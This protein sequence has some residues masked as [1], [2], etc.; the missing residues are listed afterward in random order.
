[1]FRARQKISSL[2]P[3]LIIVLAIVLRPSFAQILGGG[4]CPLVKF[5]VKPG[6]TVCE[7]LCYTPGTRAVPPFICSRARREGLAFLCG[8][9]CCRSGRNCLRLLRT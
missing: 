1:M 9:G 5:P 3:M 2:M 8:G 6:Q 7:Q 4:H